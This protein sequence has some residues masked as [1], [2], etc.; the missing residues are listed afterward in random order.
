[1]CQLCWNS[2]NPV[3]FKKTPINKKEYKI[4]RV[5]KVGKDRTKRYSK[6]RALY[7]NKHQICEVCN[8]SKSEEIHHMCGRDGDNLF[9][10]F[11]ATC[12]NCHN[13]IENNPIWAK[14]N[15]YSKTRLSKK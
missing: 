12:R 15:N 7:L 1:M 8:L 10:E 6:L 3:T 9:T 11:L 5:S 14:E 2:E 13:K 4:V